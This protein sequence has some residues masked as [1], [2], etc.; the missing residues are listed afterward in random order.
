MKKI[1][2]VEN[3]SVNILDSTNYIKIEED[4]QHIDDKYINIWGEK[5]NKNS[6]SLEKG[7]LI[8]RRLYWI[9]IMDNYCGI[10]IIKF[11][12]YMAY[13]PDK[14]KKIDEYLDTKNSFFDY[15]YIGSFDYV[16]KK[17]VSIFSERMKVDID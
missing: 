10:F 5:I 1:A 6:D 14:A 16:K 3:R 15:E 12:H 13:R 9:K 2:L 7:D 4:G 11:K 8:I 17:I